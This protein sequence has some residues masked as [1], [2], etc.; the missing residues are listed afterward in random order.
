VH[1]I[2]DGIWWAIATVS[3]VGYGDVVPESFLGRLLGTGLIILGLGIFVTITANYLAL[4]LQRE[5]QS[6]K[7]QGKYHPS[8]EPQLQMIDKMD[9]LSKELNKLS[10][11]LDSLQKKVDKQ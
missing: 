6:A 1:N 9:E 5:R 10:K 7:E 2:W 3:T 4:L 11:K 8:D